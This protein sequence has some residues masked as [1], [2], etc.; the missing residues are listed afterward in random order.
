VQPKLLPS[1][2]LATAMVASGCGGTK[3]PTR[4]RPLCG[5]YSI[6]P[7]VTPLVKIRLPGEEARFVRTRTPIKCATYVRVDRR[8]ATNLTLGPSASC[9][10]SEHLAHKD[11]NVIVRDP[12]NVLL[13]LGRG[14]V[15]CTIQGKAPIRLC[16]QG[17]ILPSGTW[18]GRASCDP[19]PEF[20]VATFAGAATVTDPSAEQTALRED[21]ELTF[22]FGEEEPQL[23]EAAFSPAEAAVFEEQAE[24]LGVDPESPTVG[25]SPTATVAGPMNLVR[26]SVSGNGVGQVLVGNPGEWAGPEPISFAYQWQ[27][28]CDSSG[29]GCLD[30]AGATAQAYVPQASDCPG[31]RLVVTA[32]NVEGVTQA[33]SDFHDLGCA[34]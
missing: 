12:P 24:S 4:P 13:R 33:F 18:Q 29:G 2:W 1:L 30:V 25:P 26:P 34:G 28:A 7:R 15:H 10:L 21:E 20:E 16:G 19:D 22:A 32:T 31:V 27:G 5:G 6:N 17:G 8:G 11:A 9:Q 23:E 3:E 14:T